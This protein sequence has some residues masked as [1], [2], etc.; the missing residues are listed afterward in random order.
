MKY[1]LKVQEVYRFDSDS[2]ATAFIEQEKES[3]LWVVKKH[4][5]EFKEVKVKGEVVD[6]YYKVTVDKVF[7]DEK[8][9]EVT[10]LK[11]KYED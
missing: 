11:L 8:E 6:T 2:E 9:P 10:S 1:L 3:E 7:N 4:N 5:V